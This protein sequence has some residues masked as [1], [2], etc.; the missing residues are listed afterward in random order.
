M[1]RY[2]IDDMTILAKYLVNQDIKRT[3]RSLSV[4]WWTTLVFIAK[5]LFYIMTILNTV[6]IVIAASV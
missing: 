1:H 3:D 5:A 2:L 6:M 4:L